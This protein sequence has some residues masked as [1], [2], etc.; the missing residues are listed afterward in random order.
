M[1]LHI[2]IIIII[3]IIIMS[4]VRQLTLVTTIADWGVKTQLFDLEYVS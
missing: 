4:L 1:Y 3:I 2:I